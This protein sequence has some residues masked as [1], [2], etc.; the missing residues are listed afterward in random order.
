MAPCVAELKLLVLPSPQ[1]T[2]TFQGLSLTPASLKDPRLKLTEAPSFAVWSDGATVTGAT[3]LTC[4]L[5][6][7]SVFPLSLSIIRAR[8]MCVDGPSGN[9]QLF[10][11]LSVLPVAKS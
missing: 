2:V 5:I 9:T 7:Y 4:T 6:V 3:L 10:V 11:G 1:F 8:T